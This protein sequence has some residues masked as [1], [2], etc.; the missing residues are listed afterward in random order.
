VIRKASEQ[1]KTALREIWSAAF[2][3]PPVYADF[4][5]Q[6]CLKLGSV[7]Y[8]DQGRSFITL[9]P[10]T[11]IKEGKVL[12]NG[13]YLYGLAT[14]PS[15]Q[16]KG[17]GSRLL[18]RAVENTSFCLLYPAT[19]ELQIFYH[20]RGFTTPVRIPEPVIQNKTVP[21]VTAINPKVLYGQY[22]KDARKQKF[23]FLWPEP[24]FHFALEEC[25]FRKGFVIPPWFC[26]P[27][28]GQVLYKPYAHVKELL[29]DSYLQGWGFFKDKVPGLETEESIFYLPLD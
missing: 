21:G 6:Y 13:F 17:F 29:V 11:L 9:F 12:L 26:Y 10:L 20:K 3:D 19:S 1:D 27:E 24:M 14:H 25:L 23:V 28:E 18:S 16:G 15:Q 4:V 22:L 5:T 8:D 2:K 7:L